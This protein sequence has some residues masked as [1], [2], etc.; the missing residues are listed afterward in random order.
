MAGILFAAAIA[1]IIA[2]DVFLH[3]AKTHV[4]PQ[5]KIVCLIKA[6]VIRDRLRELHDY[7]EVIEINDQKWDAAIIYRKEGIMYG[8]F[9]QSRGCKMET[10]RLYQN[11]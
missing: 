5:S 11:G 9:I 7:V 10:K 4:D 6:V 3:P 2:W 1:L 8:V